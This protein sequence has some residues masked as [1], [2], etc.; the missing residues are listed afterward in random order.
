[1]E[2]VR[3]LLI[4]L[5]ELPPPGGSKRTVRRLEAST[6]PE[7]YEYLLELKQQFKMMSGAEL[8]LPESTEFV[9]PIADDPREGDGS[10]AD[11]ESGLMREST[12]QEAAPDTT[13]IR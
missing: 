3:N 13:S 1:M 8:V 4:K 12:E 6:G 9:D 11:S 10:D 5:G 2:Q 7:T